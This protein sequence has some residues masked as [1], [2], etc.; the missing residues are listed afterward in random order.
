MAFD[1]APDAPIEPRFSTNA[2]E[3]YPRFSKYDKER[4]EMLKKWADENG[5]GPAKPATL[6]ELQYKPGYYD[7]VAQVIHVEQQP[8]VLRVWDGTQPSAYG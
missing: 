2:T 5:L 6:S 3:P 4:V 1:G 7:I 8:D